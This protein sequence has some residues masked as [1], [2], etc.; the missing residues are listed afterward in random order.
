VIVRLTTA[1]VVAAA[2]TT[3]A[4]AAAAVL[5]SPPVNTSPP[6]IDGVLRAGQVVNA[7]SA[8]SGSGE[9][10]FAYQWQRCD[11]SGAACVTI[12]GASAQSY[13]LTSADV[14]A[15]IRVVVT[16]TNAGG[17]TS[18][19]SS[20]TAVVRA[21]PAGPTVL[22]P[23]GLSGAAAVGSTLTAQNG[24][25]SGDAP[26]SYAYRW[27]RCPIGGTVCADI[28]N[29]VGATYVPSAADSG[30]QL[31]VVVIATNDVT[32]NSATSALTDIVIGG[33]AAPGNTTAPAI[34]GVPQVGQTLSASSGVW[35]GTP[36]FTFYYQWLR[37][38]A[39]GCVNLA[40]ATD[41]TYT[42]TSAD[43]GRRLAVSVTAVIAAGAG[44]ARSSLTDVATGAT[45]PVNFALPTLA[46]RA[47]VGQTLSVSPGAWAGLTPLSFTYQWQLC[48]RPTGCTNIASATGAAYQ[49]GPSDRGGGLRAVVT[50]SNSLGSASATSQESAAVAAP[51]SLESVVLGD[52]RI[53]VPASILIAP[54]RL[55]LVGVVFEPSVIR[56]HASFTVRL[57]VGDLA[58]RIVR[59]ARIGLRVVPEDAAGRV[60]AKRTDLN[61]WAVFAFRPSSGFVLR[62][63]SLALFVQLDLP[64]T[65]GP[66]GISNRALVPV[67]VA[68][69]RP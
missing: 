52:G 5:V 3:V 28:A 60:S 20:A 13:V 29:A 16:A 27:Q 12:G 68:S 53:S 26:I 2:A 4:T 11:A 15:T 47:E 45:A 55:I 46:G 32:S 8:W 49:P 64:G 43:S 37:C 14:D 50:A 61:G 63:G 40:G 42:V 22:A 44:R 66:A 58:G 25:W 36:P 51:G 57:R 19:T 59:G 69:P 7:S 41:R 34:A 35:S 6:G 1:A 38:T 23:P 54:D 67:P 62:A 31:R 56:S 17:S 30:Q 24:S 65:S 33:A 9:I 18:A 10:D 21:A 48:T 39:G